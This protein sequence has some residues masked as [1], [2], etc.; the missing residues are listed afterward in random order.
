MLISKEVE[1]SWSYKSREHY[2]RLGYVYTKQRD[3]FIVPIE[4]LHK[5][6]G[7]LIEIQCDYCGKIFTVQ[8]SVLIA[9]QRY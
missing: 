8:I 9:L 7:S 6:S 4:H 5:G 3:K 2:E 1:V